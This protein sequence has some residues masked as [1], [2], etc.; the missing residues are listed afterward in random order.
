[1]QVD[2]LLC[3]CHL[4]FGSV[5]GCTAG[6]DEQADPDARVRGVVRAIAQ[7]PAFRKRR[8]PGR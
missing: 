6:R 5:H 7:G 3:S 1:M 2:T 4:F 8:L